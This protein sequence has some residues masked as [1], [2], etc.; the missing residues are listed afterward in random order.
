MDWR[1]FSYGLKFPFCKGFTRIAWRKRL[2]AWRKRFGSEQ[3]FGIGWL[4]SRGQ[5][6]VSER[7][8]FGRF[9]LFWRRIDKMIDNF[10]F[11]TA[12]LSLLTSKLTLVS[13]LRPGI[14]CQYI[15]SVISQEDHLTQRS[16]MLIIINNWNIILDLWVKWSYWLIQ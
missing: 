16:R 10:F 12:L 1:F 13:L 4:E 14:T 3:K 15:I 5:R 8:P 9:F 11:R 2:I 7:E 6:R